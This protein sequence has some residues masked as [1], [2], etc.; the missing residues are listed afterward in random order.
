MDIGVVAGIMGDDQAHLCILQGHQLLRVAYGCPAGI[1]CSGGHPFWVSG[2][3]WVKARDLKPNARLHAV[4]GT[5]AIGSIKQT[6]F[7]PTYNLIVA[8]F[9]TYFVGQGKILSHD[10]TIREPT[11]AVVPGLI[12]R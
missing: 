3:G 9:H 2:E 10:N 12:D 11:E 4:D 7:E 6:G 8:D 1:H 5:R